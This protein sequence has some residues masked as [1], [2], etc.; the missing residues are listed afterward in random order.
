MSNHPSYHCPA[1]HAMGEVQG[2][3]FGLESNKSVEVEAKPERLTS[4]AGA[5]LMRE[6]SDRL[7]LPALIR[8]HLTDPRDPARTLHPFLELVRT[9]VLALAQGW[10]NQDDVSLLRD[11]P[12]FRLAV[13][14]RLGDSP[15][16]DPRARDP[17]DLCSQNSSRKPC[18]DLSPVRFLTLALERE[19]GV[20]LPH[21]ADVNQ[22][23]PH[24]PKASFGCAP[25]G[26]RERP[27]NVTLGPCSL[28]GSRRWTEPRRPPR[29]CR[30]SRAVGGGTPSRASGPCW[31]PVRLRRRLPHP[32]VP[33]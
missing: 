1:R 19:T 5:L 29:H 2:T 21:G 28:R 13:S 9:R 14:R 4:D 6:L 15:L 10:R 32:S 8:R 17:E 30:A 27:V 20:G 31:Q 18:Q 25:P 7:G 22:P 11:D 33:R 26:A 23:V 3:L 12:A 16:R 24:V